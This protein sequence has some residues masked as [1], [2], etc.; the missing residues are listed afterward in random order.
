[1]ISYDVKYKKNSDSNILRH[2]VMRTV[3]LVLK[4][5]AG[6]T[7]DNLVLHTNEM[8]LY[9]RSKADLVRKRQMK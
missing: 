7:I 4:D 9:C 1:M 3:A 2:I 5:S 6:H 8:W